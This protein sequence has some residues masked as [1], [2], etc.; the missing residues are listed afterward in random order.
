MA[1]PLTTAAAVYPA[2][3]A[4]KKVLGPTLDIIGSDLAG[5][6]EIGRDKILEAAF[7]KI[8][9]PDDGKFANLRVSRDVFMN[10]SFS[11]ADI[12]V[13]YF[14]GILASSRSE[15]G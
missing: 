4:A 11:Y 6:Y 3:V 10:G 13:E 14:S 1:D 2:S 5:L 8:D 12:S 9:N 7:N 15:D